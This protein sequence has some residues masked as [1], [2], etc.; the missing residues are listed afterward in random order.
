MYVCVLG[1]SRRFRSSSNPRIVDG[2]DNATAH[3]LTRIE[4]Q[5][6]LFTLLTVGTSN[7]LTDAVVATWSTG[8]TLKNLI[9]GLQ[10]GIVTE[11]KKKLIAHFHGSVIRG[12]S[13]VHATI[14]RLTTYFY[15][16][17]LLQPLPIPNK[18]WQDISMDFIES[19]PLSYGKSVLLMVVD[20][21]SKQLTVRQ[22]MQLKLSSKFYGPIQIIEK[23]GKSATMG[24]FPQPDDEG[25]IA[26]SPWKLLERKLVRLV[27]FGLIQW[28][29]GTQE[30][31][32]WEK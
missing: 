30:D 4:R 5:G 12:H 11:R 3:A 20:K 6:V 24:E 31:A 17:G 1:D 29:I 7:E 15:W 19:L 27:V 8:T 26:A 13:G 9:E 2:K 25:L 16:K 21:L 32:T 28:S 14:K 23:V 18:I 10:Q 22:G